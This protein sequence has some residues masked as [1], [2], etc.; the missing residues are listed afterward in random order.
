M[1]QIPRRAALLGAASLL[2]AAALPETAGLNDY[3]KRDGRFYGAAIDSGLLAGDPAYMDH[4]AV[5]CGILTGEASFKWGAL[6]PKPDAYSFGKADALM[7]YAQHHSMAVRGHALLWHEDNP[8]WLVD[9]LAPANAAPL[10]T[11]HI[12][13]VAG[14]FRSRVVHWDV[15]NEVLWPQD[16]K[17]L[18]LRDTLW[19]RAMGPDFLDVA[20]HTCAEADPASLRFINE[21]GLDYAWD[22]DERKRQAMLALLSR[23]KDR[24]VP[25]Q[26][27]GMQAHLDAAVKELDQAKLAQF[28]NDVAAL[29]MKIAI[30][31][32][33][34]RDNRLPADTV[35]RDDAVASHTRRY[36][37]AVL[38]C[39]AVLGV[40]TW[41]LSDR[42]S[43]LND[44]LPR[45][46][47]LPQRPLPLDA[48]LRR[49]KMW[50]AIADAFATAPP[51]G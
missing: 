50:Q 48:D 30:T 51:R 47:K 43:W 3:A 32:L 39:P 38:S 49:K 25:V 17:P 8:A 35:I 13:T 12:K 10:L 42:R 1:I 18:G 2:G 37:D 31:E 11:S 33:D 16:A 40:V 19:Y 29:G 9:T 28:C 4:V 41:G 36:L 26:G 44:K 21:Y 45:E 27:L 34:V 6:R 15:V 7:T 24:G 5:E 23:L 46:D 14:H 20:F 22:E